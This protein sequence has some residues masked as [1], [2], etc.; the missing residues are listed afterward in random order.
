[1]TTNR[2]ADASISGDQLIQELQTQLDAKEREIAWLK[3]CQSGK[4][5]R[6]QALFNSM[7]E[8]F[9]L[10]EIILDRDDE[11][12]DYRFIEINP[13]FEQLTGLKYEEVVWKTV[14]EVIPEIETY[15]I[16]IC[17]RAAIEGTP[18]RFERY[19]A[20]LGRW[21]EGYATELP[22][23]SLPLCSQTLRSENNQM[24]R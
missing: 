22:L 20:P 10:H 8:G 18:V 11:P 2:I 6:F 3:S 1:M 4:E 24:Q 21:Y 5:S 12:I 13:A 19:S 16:E 15:W 9:A 23:G 7:S 17:G 14:R